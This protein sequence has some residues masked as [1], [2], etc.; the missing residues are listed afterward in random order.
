MSFFEKLYRVYISNLG[1]WEQKRKYLIKKGANIG[2]GTRING[3]LD[4][5]GTEPY[6]IT[7]GKDCLFAKFV[8][9]ITHDGGVKVL[10]SLD[11]YPEKNGDKMGRVV[12]GDNTYIGMDAYVMPG[13]HIGSNCIVGAKSV[14]T[15][16]VEDNTVVAGIPAR[17]I[18]TIDEYYKKAADKIHFTGGLPYEEK[19]KFYQ[20]EQ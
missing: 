10:N 6:L 2:E 17:K 14:V 16:D 4:T 13:V 7:V 8:K 20:S 9:L 12:I 15:K 19:K 1:S 11:Y 5:F 3:G 18:C